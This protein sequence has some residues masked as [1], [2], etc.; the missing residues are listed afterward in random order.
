[1]YGMGDPVWQN[2]CYG[3]IGCEFRREAKGSHEIWWHP[4]K[5]LYTT[6]PRHSGTMDTGTVK[7]VLDDLQ[8]RE[9]ILELFT[10]KQ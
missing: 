5:R 10:G 4:A 6:I 7:K 9:Q 8:V 1:M 2:P 3:G